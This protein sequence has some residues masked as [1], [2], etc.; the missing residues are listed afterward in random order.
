MAT[1]YVYYIQ[2]NKAAVQQKSVY[3]MQMIELSKWGFP[4]RQTDAKALNILL[5]V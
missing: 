3:N 5:H 2:T 4:D 1:F